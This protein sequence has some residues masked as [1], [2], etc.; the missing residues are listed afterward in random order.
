MPEAQRE[1]PAELKQ[2][3]RERRLLLV[4]QGVIMYEERLVVPGILWGHVLETVYTGNACSATMQAE[5]VQSV[6]WLETA[7]DIMKMSAK[8]K[9]YTGQA[10]S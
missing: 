2:H 9:E 7:Q 8:Y 6:F 3:H 4:E 5:A 1:R 10:L